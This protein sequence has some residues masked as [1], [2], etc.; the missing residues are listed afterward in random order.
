M[1]AEAV[2]TEHFSA[3]MSEELLNA[4]QVN[5]GHHLLPVLFAQLLCDSLCLHVRSLHLSKRLIQRKK[6]AGAVAQLLKSLP[7]RQETLSLTPQQ[8]TN[9]P[10]MLTHA[11]QANT[12][13][14]S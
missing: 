10:G 13:T 14:E 2:M 6:R 7:S 11:R 3:D 12:Y 9:Y 5:S 1:P 8:H 4:S